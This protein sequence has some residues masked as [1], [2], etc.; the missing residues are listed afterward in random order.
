[1]NV[2]VV[3][4]SAGADTTPSGMSLDQPLAAR[5]PLTKCEKYGQAIGSQSSL[6]TR[7]SM[8]CPLK[9][10]DKRCQ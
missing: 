2:A 1:M 3:W 4:P 10:V 5:K 8:G 9:A 7:A 6:H